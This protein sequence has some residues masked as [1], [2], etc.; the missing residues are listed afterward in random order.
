[1]HILKNKRDALMRIDH[2][3]QIR[4]SQG[5][6]EAWISG[7][8]VAFLVFMGYGIIMSRAAIYNGK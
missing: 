4:D 1:M 5:C 3:E 6:P 7:E 8:I 2:R